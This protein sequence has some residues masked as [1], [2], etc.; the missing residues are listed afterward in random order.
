M[1]KEKNTT[2]THTH[3]HKR[4]QRGLNSIQD[5]LRLL[6]NRVDENLKSLLLNTIGDGKGKN[7]QYL[8]LFLPFI[9]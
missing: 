3:I 5:S 7:P 4:R 1:N 8:S 9:L 2:H 6:S